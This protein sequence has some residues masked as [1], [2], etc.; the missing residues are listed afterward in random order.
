MYSAVI[1]KSKLGPRRHL[2]MTKALEKKIPRL[3]ATDGMPESGRA[4]HTKYFAGTG[5]TF[6]PVE[7]DPVQRLFF[8]LVYNPPYDPELGYMSLDEMEQA[9][10]PM[11]VRDS[12]TGK[13]YVFTTFTER[14]K[15]WRPKT[16]AQIREDLAKGRVP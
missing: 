14:D 7:Y 15:W 3:Y 4:V 13:Q 16:L 2:L 11:R 12:A 10:I 9:K 6:Y 1:G 8:G 5:W